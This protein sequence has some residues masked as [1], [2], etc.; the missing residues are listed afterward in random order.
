MKKFLLI[1]LVLI[2][3]SLACGLTDQA[4]SNITEG[5]IEQVEQQIGDVIPEDLLTDLPDLLTEIPG[6]ILTQ[7]PQGVPAADGT[8]N[9]DICFPSEYIPP[10]LSFFEN[11][12]TGELFDFP[13]AENQ[14][15]YSIQLPPGTYNAY[16]WLYDF[17]YGGSYSESV[18]CGLDVSCTN[19]SLVDFAVTANAPTNDIDL[20]DWYG[21]LNIIPIPQN[22][23]MSAY[24]GSIAGTLSYPSEMIPAMM[25]VAR[26]I[27]NASYSYVL[28]VDH[29]GDFQIDGLAPGNYT[30]IS[31]TA[32]GDLGGG[33]TQMVPCGLSVNC[34]DHSLIPVTVNPGQ[35]TGGVMPHDWYAPAGTFPAKPAP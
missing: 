13:I 9:G 15:T 6:D 2:L 27:Q 34:N 30:V 1:I 11:V 21:D 33:Y 8:V 10:M 35:I 5:I 19:H 24:T 18:L 32:V 12:N 31:Y 14:S 4:V 26:N 3:T 7:I 20:C 28:T 16:A 23:D 17:S 25:V 29:Q 22:F